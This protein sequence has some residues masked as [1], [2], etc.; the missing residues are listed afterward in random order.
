MDSSETCDHDGSRIFVLLTHSEVGGLPL[1]VI[2]TSSERVIQK[3]QKFALQMIQIQSAI[4]TVWTNSKCLLCIF[5]LLQSI[6][7]WLLKGKNN[8]SK[9][10]Q[11]IFQNHFIYSKTEK[12][13]ND[14]YYKIAKSKIMHKK[15]IGQERSY[16]NCVTEIHC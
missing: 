15:N 11:Y 2:I 12:E 3:G 16:G 1:G 14:N 13:C 10:K 4:K 7:R 8:I 9:D 5:H 6:W